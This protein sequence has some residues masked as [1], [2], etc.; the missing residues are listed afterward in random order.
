MSFKHIIIVARKIDLGQVKENNHS[1]L[2]LHS[3]ILLSHDV[4]ISFY[5]YHE[6]TGL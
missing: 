1:R 5:V 6:K 4:A 2:S 3:W